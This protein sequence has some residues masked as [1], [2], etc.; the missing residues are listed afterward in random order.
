[1][2][3]GIEL[4]ATALLGLAMG[5]LILALDL[6]RRAAR[7]ESLRQATTL[8]RSVRSVAAHL[9]KNRGLVPASALHAA[10]RTLNDADAVY[11]LHVVFGRAKTGC[12]TLGESIGRLDLCSNVRAAHMLS[13]AGLTRYQEE[14][15]ALEDPVLRT[16]RLRHL[17]EAFAL[18][19]VLHARRATV[20]ARGIEDHPFARPWVVT[21][22]REPVARHLSG[23][24]YQKGPRLIEAGSSPDLHETVR[25]EL[26][27]RLRIWQSDEEWIEEELKTVFGFDPFAE[28][29]PKERGWVQRETDHA[30]LL[31]I[32]LESFDR[33]PE[34]LGDFFE[35]PPET[36]R[37]HVRNT[38]R[39][40]PDRDL[41]VEVMQ[42]LVLPRDE[43]ERFY[44]APGVTHFY[45]AEE[46]D[47]FLR[48]WTSGASY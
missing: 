5:A 29:F 30:R 8:R 18:R 31:Q 19:G 15:Y 32:R 33:L 37:V 2:T 26:L 14:T 7:L 46:I 17:R 28:P 38:A 10:D 6:R 4:A 1:M 36:I 40:R 27:E 9:K 20:R 39:E 23:I 13:G 42:R 48:R 22:L 44:A 12:T 24:F 11:P 45:T 21:T 34:A 43:L 35:I 41:Y 3:F 47:G 16:R 25:E